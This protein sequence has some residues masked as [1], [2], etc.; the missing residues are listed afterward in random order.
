MKFLFTLLITLYSFTSLAQGKI[1]VSENLEIL[2]LSPNSF[3]HISFIEYKGSK[4]PCNGLVYMNGNEAVVMDT[5]TDDSVS[6][7]LLDWMKKQY[8]QVKVTAIIVNHFHNDCLGGLKAFH[9]RGVASYANTR[10][11]KLAK[12]DNVVVPQNGFKDRLVLNI[13]TSEVIS[14][15]QGPAHAPDNIVTWIPAEKLLFGGCMVK[16]VGAN[17]GNLGDANE[18]KWPRTIQH[19]KTAYPDAR[20]IVPGHGQYGGQELLDYT[21]KLFN[22]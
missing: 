10:T 12:R 21:M 14:T 4:V 22:N 19:V 1:V 16:E 20:V 13:G 18:K 11:I 5:P 9:K 17:K 3:I 2:P 7:E 8:P 15:W 6:N